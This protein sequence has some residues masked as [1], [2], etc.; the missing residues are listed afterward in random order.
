M[1]GLD[2]Y[3]TAFD[4]REPEPER[5]W[6]IEGFEEEGSFPAYEM[7]YKKLQTIPELKNNEFPE[8]YLYQEGRA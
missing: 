3:I 1:N 6:L 7:A 4:D 5:W 2:E 8:D